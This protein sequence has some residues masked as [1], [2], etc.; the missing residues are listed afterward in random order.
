MRIHGLDFTS[1]PNKRKPLTLA[2]GWLANGRLTIETLEKWPHFRGF[3]VFLQNQGP[4]VV[5]MD[6]AFGQPLALLDALN[7]PHDWS[8][9]VERIDS[10]GKHEWVAMIDRFVHA[11]PKGQKLLFRHTDRLAGAQSPMKMYYIPV[12]RMFF[13]GATRLWASELSV[14]PNRPRNDDRIA[15]EVYPALI[16]RKLVGRNSGYKSDNRAQQTINAVQARSAILTQIVDQCSSLYGFSL[17]IAPELQTILVDDAS[18][19]HLDAVLSTVQAG[20][21]YKQRNHNY[22]IPPDA[23]PAEGWIVDPELLEKYDG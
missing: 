18:G 11:Q 6:F 15:I 23:H 4:F 10:M 8:Q 19:D 22:G 9:Y 16:V 13:Q 2:S 12:G 21:A 1:A 20:W 3:E 7:F 14:L 5:G 17:S